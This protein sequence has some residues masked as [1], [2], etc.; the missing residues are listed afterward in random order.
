MKISNEIFSVLKIILVTA[1]IY[2][3]IYMFGGLFKG[4]SVESDIISQYNQR[5]SIIMQYIDDNNR[6]IL[7]HTNRQ[8]S[9]IVIKQSNAAE[10]VELRRELEELGISIENLRSSYTISSST[11]DSITTNV[12][13]ISDTLDIFSFEDSTKH[14]NVSGI[15]DLS[16]DKISLHHTYHS[17][18]KIFSYEE[19]A[20]LFKAPEMRLKI[21]ADDPNN[22]IHLQ[23]FTIK[24]QREIVS[25][26]IGVGASAILDNNQVKVRPSLQVGIY[27]KIF[28]IKSKK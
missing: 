19:R 10:M 21:I 9:P 28:T 16:N 14:L 24:Q 20:K 23:T 6:L 27:K 12:I 11:S 15:V 4:N 5:D 3:V 7:E 2:Y 25:V 13:R 18:Y 17:K 22:D 1:P 8:Y 26:G